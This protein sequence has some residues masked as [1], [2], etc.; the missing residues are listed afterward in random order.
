MTI[1]EWQHRAHDYACS[2]GWPKGSCSVPEVL[3]LIHEEVSEAL[4]AYRNEDQT[5]FAV[6]LADI[7]LRL[8]DCAERFGV[9]LEPEMWEKHQKNVTRPFRHGKRI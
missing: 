8:C 4:K 2:N 3:C 9:N 6:E 5:Q 1:K 7:A